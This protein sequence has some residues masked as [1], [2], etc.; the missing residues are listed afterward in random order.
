[1]AAALARHSLHPVSRALVAAQ[2]DRAADRAG[3]ATSPSWHADD[4]LETAGMGL[5]G[6]VQCV[7]GSLDRRGG[8]LRLGSPRHCGVN[9]ADASA[10][11]GDRNILQVMLADTG[12]WLA[13][14]ELAERVRPQA[15]A[16]VSA[17]RDAG[18]RVELLSGDRSGAVQRVAAEVGITYSVGD[19]TPQ[20]KLEH[21]QAAQQRGNRVAMVGDGLNDGPSLAG[22]HVSFAFGRAVPLAQ[23]KA[24][25]VVL[26][27]RLDVVACT[28]L[29]ARR[30]LRIVRQ[31]LWWAGL[32]NAVC[33]PL[34]LTGWLPAW[35]AG[36]GMAASSLLV[37]LNAA[38]L[39]RGL[40]M[41][42]DA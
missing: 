20:G 5:T 9:S 37:V 22:A 17:L 25:F 32:Y 35:L 6:D 10:G 2:R 16:A 14:F 24:D 31:N 7:T 33:I 15:A 28:L 11:Q 36:L 29:Q 30:T 19:V 3:A 42:G 39:S 40:P 1:M 34:A 41:V 21:L 23:N 4:V 18:I 27:D 13:T 26:G 38:R 12:G 8:T